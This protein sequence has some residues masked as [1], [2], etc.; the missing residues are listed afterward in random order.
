MDPTTIR[1]SQ[2]SGLQIGTERQVLKDDS[3]INKENVP[4]I[5]EN[6]P[7]QKT[8]KS[9][10]LRVK[11]FCNGPNNIYGVKAKDLNKAF[12]LGHGETVS[13]LMNSGS[14]TIHQGVLL[15]GIARVVRNETHA[16]HHDTMDELKKKEGEV[17]FDGSKHTLTD[18]KG[19]EHE[20]P[21]KRSTEKNGDKLDS[22]SNKLKIL[23]KNPGDRRDFGT[24]VRTFKMMVMEPSLN[25]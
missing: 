22:V 25:N 1:G 3:R 21:I 18:S 15:A 10:G 24:L 14:D 2:G 7:T 11:E 12:E 4:P 6:Q 20:I 8:E 9:F 13:K 19:K 17:V 5:P 23:T 16:A